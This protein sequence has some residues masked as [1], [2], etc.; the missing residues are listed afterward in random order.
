MNAVIYARFSSHTQTEQSIDGQLAACRQYAVDNGITIVNE[1]I[2]RGIS[3]KTHNRPEFQKMVADSFNKN[4]EAVLVWS[5]DRFSRDKTDI[6]L[7]KDL[8]KKNGVK[9]ISATERIDNSPSGLLLEGLY[10]TLSVYYSE[11]LS[12]KVKR[13]MHMNA[14]KG[15]SNGSNPGLGYRVTADKKFEVDEAAAEVV[16]EIYRRYDGGE[17]V[18]EIINDLNRRG[19][20]TSLGRPFKPTSLYTILRNQRYIGIY[21]FA[22]VVRENTMPVTVDKDLFFSVQDKLKLNSSAPA[23]SRKKVDYLLTTKLFC[24]KCLSPMT[25]YSGMGKGEKY[26]YY[27]CKKSIGKNKSCSKKKAKKDVIENIVVERCLALLTEEN[28]DKI[29]KE[30]DKY[31][32][33]KQKNNYEL[34]SIEKKI[35]DCE[36]SIE[37]LFLAIESGSDAQLL[38]ERIAL[39]KNELTTLKEQLSKANAKIFIITEDQV[40][41]F[42]QKLKAEYKDDRTSRKQLINIF[43]ERVILYD[44]RLTIYYHGSDIHEDC[45]LGDVEKSEKAL[46]NQQD[47]KVSC[48]VGSAPP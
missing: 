38:S 25:G 20:K 40:K 12:V 7:Y 9:V 41:A 21:R 17:T 42:F 43:I 33:E 11:E 35:K 4:F 19:I 16:R 14:E 36:K 22:D 45:S 31:C 10:E 29:A 15:L 28:I 24:G 18:T 8:L 5:F 6:A 13:G 47:E 3:G 34:Q 39:R 30:I 46:N 32:K 1:Y 48:L 27:A 37:N 2:D 44:D 23:R 26:S